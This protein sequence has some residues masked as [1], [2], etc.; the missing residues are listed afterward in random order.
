MSEFT[1]F[2]KT[3]SFCIY[4]QP[5]SSS[6][7]DVSLRVAICSGEHLLTIRHCVVNIS[8]NFPTAKAVGAGLL[9][10][11]VCIRNVHLSVNNI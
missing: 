11:D 2:I 7:Q 1:L 6:K 10:N 4:Q 9:S 8:C 5:F 3:T